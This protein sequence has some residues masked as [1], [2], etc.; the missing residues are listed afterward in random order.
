MQRRPWSPIG[1]S[2]SIFGSN[3]CRK[4]RLPGGPSAT[5]PVQVPPDG[6]KTALLALQNRSFRHTLC[7][8]GHSRQSVS[9]IPLFVQ[10]LVENGGYPEVRLRPGLFKYPRMA[11]NRPSWLCRI[12]ILVSLGAQEAMVASRSLQFIFGTNPCRT[13][14]LPGGLSATRPVQVSRMALKRPSWLYRIVVF[15]SLCAQE[16]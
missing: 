1:L 10:I 7:T 3:H 16:A 9:P 2:N 8:G 12:V 11:L 14:R 4:R 15:A 13:R 6:P 5:R